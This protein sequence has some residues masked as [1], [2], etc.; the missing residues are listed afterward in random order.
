MSHSLSWHIF[1]KDWRL[2]WPL[3]VATALLQLM[4]MAVIRHSEPFPMPEAKSIIASLLT[5]GL[6]ISMTLLILLTIQQ[7]AIPSTNQDW[8]TRPVKRSDLLLGK[9]FTI[10]LLVHGPIVVAD[11]LRGLTEGF[12]PGAV[13][14]A[15]LVSNFEIALCYSLPAMAVASMTRSVVEAIIFGLA[16][17]VV[18]VSVGLVSPSTGGTG[19]KWIWRSVA[20]G[21]L[22]LVTIATLW[23]QYTRRSRD[24]TQQARALF[25]VGVLAYALIPLL[26]WEPA[27]FM[28]RSL[29]ANP[30]ASRHI[31]V[32]VVQGAT[33]PT[34][35][36]LVGVDA[37]DPGYVRLVL[38]LRFSAFPAG[39]L[40]H[41]DRTTVRLIG[42]DGM[43]V[44]RGLGHVFDVLPDGDGTAGQA[45]D[46]PA[47]VYRKVSEQP[48]R[49]ELG[50]YATLL[51]RQLLMRMGLNETRRVPGFGWCATRYTT[52]V[53]DIGC[54]TA[55]A[56]PFCISVAAGTAPE[57]F[58]C[59]LNYEPV[60]LRF[61]VDPID[62]WEVKI[63]TLPKADL[64]PVEFVF[65]VYEPEDHFFREVVVPQ[66]RLRD[67]G[68]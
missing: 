32:G 39:T 46:I 10:V 53:L 7:E 61:S 23:W 58:K 21:E 15:T 6:A 20:H 36:L 18:G 13:I 25:A 14:H 2:M 65:G 54:R 47:D 9:L 38:P 40:L 64:A 50:Y 51:R 45:V 67:L 44:F 26:P 3:A 63:P 56:L 43:V 12:A 5:L 31:N 49:L 28:Q 37:P 34:H 55:G 19:L 8:L 29:A 41:G 24:G 16:M 33:Y 17:L 57:S 35:Q 27:F 62:H 68:P 59:E 30:E 66:I 1:R 42:G 11:I 52:G 48:L 4:I 22:L 60:P